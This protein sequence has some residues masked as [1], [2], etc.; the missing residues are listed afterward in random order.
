M[1]KKTLGR[2]A[3]AGLASI[4]AVSAMSIAAS[5]I[6][7]NN[8]IATGTVYA[9]T[10]TTNQTV[11]GV[12]IAGTPTTTYFTTQ[13]QADSFATAS[14]GA[15]STVSKDYTKNVEQTFGYGTAVYVSADG[16]KISNNTSSVGSGY[17]TY[18]STGTGGSGTTTTGDPYVA[19]RYQST[20][21][22]AYLGTNGKWYPNMS[23]LRAA[24]TSY[25]ASHD[26]ST[27]LTYNP[28]TGAI[29]FDTTTG[30]Y[31]YSHTPGRT[32]Q[33]YGT[34]S[35]DDNYWNNNWY[36]S[37]Y[38]T[39]DVYKV[40][41]VYYPTLNSALSA[42]NQNYSLLT[43]VYDYSA[44]RSNYFSQK[45][46]L[47]YPTYQEALSAS[48]NMSGLVYTMN[49]YA[50]DNYYNGYDYSN[51]YWYNGVWYSGTGAYGGDPYYYYWLQKQQSN[52]NNNSSSSS[53]SDSTTATVG[54]RKGWTSVAKYIKSLKSGASVTVDMNEETKIP[55][56]VMSALKSS[57]ATAK[58]VLD[59]GVV[60]TIKGDD[61]S[62]AKDF[63]ID[64]NYNTNMVPSKLVKA[65]Y[66]KNKAVS[67]AQI[68]IDGNSF[69]ADADVT[70]K[71]STKRAGCNAKL[72]R[73]NPDKETISLVDSAKVQ[74][75]GKCTFGDVTKGGSFVIVL[76]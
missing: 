62:S 41:G 52:K 6:D 19:Y 53:S 47:Y 64:T 32:V 59:N 9:V 23:S 22:K 75:N 49:Y 16:N 3:A 61:V 76:Y 51:G 2:F 14:T 35:T 34:T 63:Y 71:F 28:T 38:D 60:F 18:K 36:Y 42:A 58:F 72:Y 31:T 10:V 74:S 33:I 45:T 39:Y 12:T 68:T 17:Y 55:S 70:V 21:Y 27:G 66:K 48:N 30:Y 29:Y 26:L 43:K 65:A 13:A 1:K 11:G 50:N 5:A 20:T 67:T 25:S 40:N 37:D 7:V 46:G 24:G 56:N 15:S 44:P 54:N 57:G 69:G 73:Y 8:G 4:T